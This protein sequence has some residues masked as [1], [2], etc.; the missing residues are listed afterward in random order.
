MVSWLSLLLFHV[1]YIGI[2]V[3]MEFAI[4]IFLLPFLTIVLFLCLGSQFPLQYMLYFQC[5]YLCVMFLLLFFSQ[6][7]QWI[8][9][10]EI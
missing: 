10:V 5:Y 2:T 4:F 6:G 3:Y 9:D 7:I 8:L 1:V